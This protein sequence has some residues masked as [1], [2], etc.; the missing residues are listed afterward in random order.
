MK[1]TIE[2][3]EIS[4]ALGLVSSV[5]EKRQSIPILS[6]ILLKAKNSGLTLIATDLEIEL[7]FKIDNIKLQKEGSTTVSARKLADL[8]K[9]VPED[10]VL[11][12]E[13]IENQLEISALK[14]QADFSIL[15]VGDFPVVESQEFEREVALPGRELA[16]LI[17]KTSFAMAS[18]D[19]RYYLN[20]IL[21]EVS[22]SRINVVATDGHRLAWSS[23]DIK[24]DFVKDQIIIP[25]KS[26][27]ELQKLLNLYPE[28]VNIAFNSNQLKVFSDEYV[29]ISKL[30][31][32]SYPD[33]EKVFPKGAEQKLKAD[34]SLVQTA[35]NRAAVLSNEKYRGVKFIL[36]KDNLKI[37]ANNPSKE[38]A[39]EEVLVEYSGDSFEIGFN[40]S[41]IQESLSVIPNNEVE[42]VFFGSENSCIIK[43][44]DDE[45]LIHVIMPMRL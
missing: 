17:E 21:L 15:P 30:I 37:C 23:C 28:N 20:G 44:I 12:F 40:I 19:V 24:T 4:D 38:S 41:Y 27:L 8:I 26:A 3:K 9:S 32:G 25:R 18:Q 22:S 43:N 39:E 35:L 11:T 45:S 33:Y 13:L 31:E 5:A 6:N 10:T 34:K 2:K 7:T 29:F 16:N 42:F 1:F 36:E 14:F